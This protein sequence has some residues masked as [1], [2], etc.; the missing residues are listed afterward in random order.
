MYVAAKDLGRLRMPGRVTEKLWWCHLH[1]V[2]GMGLAWL[3][4]ERRYDSAG[5]QI[6]PKSFGWVL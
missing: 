5:A 4:V 6:L 1:R 2:D 3:V